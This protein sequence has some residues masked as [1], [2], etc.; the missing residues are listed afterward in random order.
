MSDILRAIALRPQRPEFHA[1]LSL[2]S[3]L[4]NDLSNASISAE[5]A[6]RLGDNSAEIRELHFLS[7]VGN[8]ELEHAVRTFLCPNVEQ[9]Q[10]E[11]EKASESANPTPT[12]IDSP[13][14]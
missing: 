3:Y 8:G 1:L 10:A 2:N 6:R 11:F 7:C 12:P 14:G 4:L 5:R 13:D 9:L